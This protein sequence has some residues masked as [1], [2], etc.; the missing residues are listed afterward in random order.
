MTVSALQF[1][2]ESGIRYGNIAAAMIISILPTLILAVSVQRY[3]VRGLSFG[4][5]K[6]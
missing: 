4:A 6:G 5:I 3:L 2:T 1:I